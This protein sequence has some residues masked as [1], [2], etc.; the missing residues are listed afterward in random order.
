MSS[1]FSSK[2]GPPLGSTEA[3]K[4]IKRQASINAK[5]VITRKYED[6]MRDA[7]EFGNG[8]VRKGALKKIIED[9]RKKRQ[10]VEDISPLAIRKRIVRNSLVNHHLA[11]GQVSLLE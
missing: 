10:I 7:K 3:S 1:A 8:Q 9:R 2:I 5:N 4:A 6:L 11:G